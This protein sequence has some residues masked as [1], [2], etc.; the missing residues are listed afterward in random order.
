[1]KAISKKNGYIHVG[2]L[3]TFEEFATHPDITNPTPALPAYMSRIAS[4]QIRNRA[5]LGGNIINASPIGDMTTLLL[6]LEAVLVL[7]NDAQSRSVPITSFFKGYKQ[8]DRIPSEILA[9]ILIPEF[10]SNTKI[11][12]EKVS[13]RKYLD[14]ASVNS[15]MKIGC[16][17]GI[18]REIGLSMGGVAPG[19]LF[20]KATSHYFIGKPFCRDG[21]EGACSSI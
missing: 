21:V 8:P 17:D 5:T 11:N 6:A 15:A 18:I 4:L 9:D 13:R 7:E 16:E 3:T 12:F 19:P 10:P 1:M 14:I 20:L 2:A